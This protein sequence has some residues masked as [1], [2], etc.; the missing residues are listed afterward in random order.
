[1]IFIITKIFI[2]KHIVDFFWGL[3]IMK[4][5]DHCEMYDSKI[6]RKQ[7][8]WLVPKSIEGSKESHQYKVGICVGQGS[9]VIEIYSLLFEQGCMGESS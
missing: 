4:R 7:K 9:L 6:L 1:V 3:Q 2:L 8:N 5:M